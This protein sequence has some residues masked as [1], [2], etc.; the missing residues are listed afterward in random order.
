MTRAERRRLTEK[1]ESILAA[2]GMPAE[3]P[4]IATEYTA[5]LNDLRA[6]PHTRGSRLHRLTEQLHSERDA[7]AAYY[8]AA[9]GYLHSCRWRRWPR[10][11]RQIWE[12]HCEGRSRAEIADAVGKPESSVQDILTRHERGAGLTQR[13]TDAERKRLSRGAA[14]RKQTKQRA[15]A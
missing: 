7:C 14:N 10:V 13:L 2:E 11:H 15:A 3:L 8:S 9:G 6:N 1:W 12:L 5:G 4:P